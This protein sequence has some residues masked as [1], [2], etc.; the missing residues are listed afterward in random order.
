MIRSLR[1][2][3]WP[4]L[5][6]L[7]LAGCA[8]R[9]AP[10]EDI[11][12]R[13]SEKP[14]AFD[15]SVLAGR[16]IVIDPGHGGSF[17]GTVGADSLR[18]ADANLG[19]ALYLWGLCTDAGAN[20]TLTRTTDRDRLPEGS[21]ELGDDLMARVSTANAVNPDVFISIHH[22]S[23][24]PRL[25][26]V[27][28]IEVYYRAD[29]PGASLELAHELQL[30]LT[31][32]LGIET[33]DVRPGNYVVLRRSTANAAV[34]GEASYLSHPTV[35]ARLKL[36]AK[37]KLE[38]EAYFYGL[39]DY[40]KGGVPT[41][42]HLSPSVDTLT[43]PAE[44]AFAAEPGGGVPLDPTSARASVGASEV[45]PS[46]DAA[47]SVI[48]IALPPDIPNGRYA[49]RASVQ[50]M[51]GRTARS[52][53]YS[54]V[55]AR[56]A[57][58]IVPLVLEPGSDSTVSLSV[59][60]LDEL[61]GEVADGTEVTAVSLAGRSRFTG[62]SIDG[63]C[64]VE[65]PA[66]L[67]AEAWAFA[68]G[69]AA[70]TIRFAVPENSGRIAVIAVDATTGARIPYAVIDLGAGPGVGGNE[71]GVAFVPDSS[72]VESL[73][74]EAPGFRPA[75]V[76]H[77]SA[78]KVGSAFYATL[79]PLF[80]GVLGGRRIAL[81]PAG[82]GT[83]PAGLGKNGLR[84]ATVNL[85]V[86]RRLRALLE[87]AGASV[88]LTRDGEETISAQ[89]RV[90][91]VNRSNAEL[92]IGIHHDTPPGPCDATRAILHYPESARGVR[93]AE[94]LASA[95]AAIPPD[96]PVPVGESAGLFLQQT[97][98][99]ACEVYGGPVEDESV[100][101]AMDDDA[102]VRVEAESVFGAVAQYFGW[103]ALLSTPLRVAV[104]RDGEPVPGATVDIDRI[105]A[106]V[107]DRDGLAAFGW[108]GT[109]THLM[110]VRSNDGRTARFE[111]KLSPE[112]TGVL[113]LE[114][115]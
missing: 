83:D 46:F 43:G 103:S 21:T 91:I 65:V 23:N 6:T 63:V 12:A 33:A 24:L 107:T 55:L 5:C 94:E 54:F 100:E 86:A 109:G 92:A 61:G 39:L 10:V 101:T 56:P 97:A 73:L 113:V 3:L 11:Y 26:S 59:R 2:I 112:R 27:N 81:D 47:S 106:R 80:G 96:G 16:T 89:E 4:V 44:I 32:N 64:T 99:A 28:K 85:A 84:G 69:N 67:T 51:R 30:H 98:C 93:F 17:D 90:Y 35:E 108:I 20:V 14:A 102:W 37:Q 49:V 88:A 22:N 40:F 9:K 77:L 95:L 38:A 68:A 48:G 114:L 7:L 71:R 31:R 75:L 57:R 52:K 79:E 19:V 45:I 42:A 66:G 110:T 1:T 72:A 50:S 53:P 18:E 105:F 111:E 15:T 74:V 41:V 78:R 70:D 62:R 25:P 104:R 36:S 87:R 13:L 115:P 76:E 58:Y 82:G 34:L 29:D 8:A 60:V